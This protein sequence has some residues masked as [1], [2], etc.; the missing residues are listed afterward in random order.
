M[1]PNVDSGDTS[2][3]SS[4]NRE[5]DI[6]DALYI[7]CVNYLEN[8]HTVLWGEYFDIHEGEGITEAASWLAKVIVDVALSMKDTNEMFEF[9]LGEGTTIKERSA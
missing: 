7:G 4:E 2:T 5:F 9:F 8:Q 6:L 3:P 1:P